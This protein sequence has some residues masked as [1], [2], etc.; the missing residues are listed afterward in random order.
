LNACITFLPASSASRSSSPAGELRQ[1]L[2]PALAQLASQRGSQSRASSG[3]ACARREAPLPVA[4]GLAPR[5]ISVHVLVD[6]VRHEKLLVGIEAHASFVART[7][8][9]PSGAPCALAVSTACGAP[10]GDVR[11]D[12][13]ERGPLG[14]GA[15]A[16]I[17]S[18]S[19]SRS[20]ESSTCWT[21]QPYASKRA[22]WSSPSNEID[23]VPSIVMW[24]SS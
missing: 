10:V 22:P 9:S 2:A 16:R 3:K 4:L 5:S 11:A 24:L 15:R 19:A 8:S 13:D 17:A 12:R 21:C 7:S 23:V 6:L 14:L 18:R 20:S 1:R